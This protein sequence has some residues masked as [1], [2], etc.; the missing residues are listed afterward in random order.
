MPCHSQTSGSYVISKIS[1]IRRV[2]DIIRVKIPFIDLKIIEKRNIRG[3]ENIPNK[4]YIPE[5][6]ADD[7]RNSWSI[8]M[9]LK[10]VGDTKP[11]CH[12]SYS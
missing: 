6:N 4:E 1:L 10:H 9:N 3:G 8:L 2:T 12:K 7:L 11:F 5:D